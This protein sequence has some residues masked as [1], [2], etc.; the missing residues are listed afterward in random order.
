MIHSRRR[1]AALFTCLLALFAACGDGGT[2]PVEPEPEP[3]PGKLSIVAGRGQT[4]S[5]QAVLAQPLVVELRDTRG[6]LMPDVELN[7]I[8][9]LVDERN[10]DVLFAPIGSNAFAPSLTARTGA[11]GRLSVQMRLD[12]VAGPVI[13]KVKTVTSG[14]TDTAT[15]TTIG[16]TAVRME[17]TPRDTTLHASVA[18]RLT[19]TGRDRYS[20]P[21]PLTRIARARVVLDGEMVQMTEIG[22]GTVVL[23]NGTFRDSVQ[24]SAVPQ[25][26]ILLSHR[27]ESRDAIIAIALDHSDVRTIY[28]FNG[29]ETTAYGPDW[30][31]DGER[32]IF[33]AGTTQGSLWMVR[34][35]G[36]FERQLP[37]TADSSAMWGDWVTPE[38]IY[39]HG[40]GFN[41]PFGNIPDRGAVYRIHPDGSVRERVTSPQW[42]H[43]HMRPRV[44][45]N[46]RWL[47]YVDTYGAMPF[48]SST[49]TL[50]LVDL[51]TGTTRSLDLTAL[52]GRWSPAGNRFATTSAGA[53]LLITPG[54]E[55]QTLA[56]GVHGR[57]EWSPDGKYILT[58]CEKLCVISVATGEKIPL[59]YADWRYAE[60]AWRP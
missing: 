24:V 12:T 40:S 19:A 31:P 57:A 25:G 9:T 45:P 35:T 34:A 39:Y 47:V 4:D 13:V 43:W 58:T 38:W 23:Q 2:P 21:V 32:V 51:A 15:I 1:I 20:N 10:A 60:P 50:T 59:S 29:R 53:L 26:T 55:Q 56:T 5:I 11:D 54:G 33:H 36:E 18:Y 6:E 42:L 52:E 14:V 7:V 48:E 16:G 30:S 46:G 27:G 44:S 8:S 3:Q 41:T 28:Q 22:R 49:G 17:A 37:V